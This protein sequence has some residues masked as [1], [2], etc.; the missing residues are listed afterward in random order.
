V[1]VV[2]ARLERQAADLGL[3][4]RPEVAADRA[5]LE[6]LYAT[7]RWE[8]PGVA[9]LPPDI[10]SV[11][12][13]QQFAAQYAHY[14]TAYRP[15]SDFRIIERGGTPVGRLYL[16]ANHDDVRIVDIALLPECRGQGIGHALI[17]TVIED[18]RA[19]GQTVSIHV[20]QF[21]PAQRLYRR[22][23]FRDVH[24]QGTYILMRIPTSVGTPG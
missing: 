11:F 14:D 9:D 22:L 1:T 17:A 12:L 21:N 20:E 3:T 13:T 5:W 19:N 7:V 6:H 15:Y 4:L 10:K 8:E 2:G 18:A 24:L 16:F 23:G